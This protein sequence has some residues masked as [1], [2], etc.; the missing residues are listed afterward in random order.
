MMVT[1]KCT[2]DEWL[3]YEAYSRR[4]G[5]LFRLLRGG[6]RSTYTGK[7]GEDVQVY[8]VWACDKEYLRWL[9]DEMGFGG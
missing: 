1:I 4:R 7:N 8:R 9:V 3:I 6:W 2:N 5:L